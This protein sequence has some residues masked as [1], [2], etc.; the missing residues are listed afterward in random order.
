MRAVPCVQRCLLG[1][2]AGWPGDRG[3]RRACGA[4]RVHTL[5]CLQ[6]SGRRRLC[7]R[8]SRMPANAS[9]GAAPGFA[10]AAARQ[11][12]VQGVTCSRAYFHVPQHACGAQRK[13]LHTRKCVQCRA[14]SGACWAVPLGGRA[15]VAS[16]VRAV[17]AVC[18]LWPASKYLAGGAC[19]AAAAACRQTLRAARRQAL[20]LRQHGSTT[21]RAS[22]AAGSI[23]TPF[24]F[25][26]AFA[27]KR[28]PT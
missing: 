6:I 23:F 25:S 27:C 21:C 7:R 1:R 9:R 5:A 12:H 28:C 24:F 13:C 8:R 15:T 16:G 4:R 2:A 18:T 14:C 11:H 20:R 3:K 22:H 10:L 19:A 17:R 26:R